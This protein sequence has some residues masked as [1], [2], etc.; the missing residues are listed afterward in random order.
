MTGKNDCHLLDIGTRTVPLRVR[1]NR[2]ARRLILRI[3]SE[4]DGAV[5]TLPPHA[6][7]EDGLQMAR[8]QVDWIAEKLSDLP[9]RVAFA[10]GAGIPLAGVNHRIRHDPDDRAGVRRESGEL[11]VSGMPEH[12]ARR[13]TDWLKAEA[14]RVIAPLAHQKAACIGHKPSRIT[15][16]DTR[17]RWG[18]C[19]AGGGLSFS[20]RL[21]LAPGSVLDYVVAHEAAHLAHLN[22][23]EDFW[24]TV[25]GLTA[26]MDKARDWLGEHG[27]MLHR[28]G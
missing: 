13:L 17:S 28:Y 2:R 12:L 7:I 5:V 21:V 8:S 22:H 26:D 14:R 3:D 15:I 1:R 9:R 20:W 4:N 25:S 11:I 27:T 19:S 23:G 24:H 16:R 10:D 6:R 18:S